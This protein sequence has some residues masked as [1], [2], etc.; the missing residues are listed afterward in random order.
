MADNPFFKMQTD[1][2]YPEAVVVNK[3]GEILAHIGGNNYNSDLEGAKYLHTGFRDE[4]MRINDDRK[5]SLQLS[6]FKEEGL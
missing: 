1:K 6:E 2:Y 4:R 5:I 3:K